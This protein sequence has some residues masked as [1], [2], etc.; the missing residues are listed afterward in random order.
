VIGA[1]HK[2]V[3]V[4]TMGAGKT[5]AIAA[6]SE[7]APLATEVTNTERELFDKDSTTVAL[8]YGAITL[9]DGERLMLYG[10]P[11][12]DRFDFMWPIVADGAIGIIVLV[13]NSR[14][15]PITDLERFVACFRGH[16]EAGRMV[17]AIGRMSA[18]P[19]PNLADY[20]AAL[21]RLD[22]CVPVM[23]A[24]VR[25]RRDV[26]RVIDVLLSQIDP[27]QNHDLGAG[28][29]DIQHTAHPRSP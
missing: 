6:I 21:D 13:D 29:H 19:R 28:L 18:H 16:A 12:Q 24:D 15:A 2:L 4:G 20:I 8:D 25:E 14:P 9:P 22:V 26:L 27:D 10:T 5:T 23:P 7:I 1:E 11:G 3:F 17:I